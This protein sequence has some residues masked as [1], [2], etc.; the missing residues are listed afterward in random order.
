MTLTMVDGDVLYRDG[1]HV[2]MDSEQVRER[3]R[4]FAA[5]I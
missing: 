2:R 1:E 3:A 4:E 5:E